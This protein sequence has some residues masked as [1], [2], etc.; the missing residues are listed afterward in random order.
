M[1]DLGRAGLS[2][3]RESRQTLSNSNTYLRKARRYNIYVFLKFIAK[4]LSDSDPQPS[5]FSPSTSGRHI[6]SWVR[7]VVVDNGFDG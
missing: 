3:F 6:A 5:H 4:A 7:G 1:R 2:G